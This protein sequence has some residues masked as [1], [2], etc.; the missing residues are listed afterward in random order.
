VIIKF[1]KNHPDAIVPTRNSEGDAAYDLYSVERAIIGPMNR[2]CIPTGLSIEIPQGFY[3]RVAPRSGLAMKKGIDVLA[4]VIDS[5]YRGDLGVILINLNFPEELLKPDSM[6]GGVQSY[7][8]LFGSRQ[9]VDL[10]VGSRVAQ[11]IIERCY[12]AEWQ[13]VDELS[14]SVR[15]DDCFG[16]SGI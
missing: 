8:S 11:L 12:N 2:A 14:D 1:K 16:S 6:K 9:N 4:G 13:E 15:Q 5:S 10:P 7:E 3:G